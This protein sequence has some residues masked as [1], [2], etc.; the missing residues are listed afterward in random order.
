MKGHTDREYQTC[1]LW[2]LLATVAGPRAA[3]TLQRTVATPE[4]PL[5]RSGEPLHRAELAH[6]LNLLLLEELLVRVPEAQL[7]VADKLRGGRPVFLDHGAV[8]SVVDVAQGTLPG[9]RETFARVLEALG[10][11]ESAV[12]PLERIRMTGY[13]YCHLD[14][15]DQI[16]QFFVS[17]LHAASFSRPFRDAAAAVLQSSVDPLDRSAKSRLDVLRTDGSLPFDEAA[18]LL[19]ALVRC[20]R[21]HHDAPRL[22]DYETLRAESSEMA[23]IATEG[24]AY[25]H[26]TDRVEDVASLA[27]EQKKLGRP[28]K[29]AVEI[30]RDGSVRQTAYRA[31]TVQRLFD[32]DAGPVLKAVPGSFIEFITRDRIERDGRS[33]LD[34]RFDAANAQGIFKMTEAG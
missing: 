7:Y 1:N 32:A 11:Q 14:C 12:Y 5:T 6:A 27:D 2:Q 8:R 16:G 26:V 34:L 17:E 4:I 9:G 21:R 25:N 19:P 31:T 23:W 3:Q 28:I 22:D 29:D 33:L 13:A 18:A 30:S 15:P 24:S 20:F 10:F